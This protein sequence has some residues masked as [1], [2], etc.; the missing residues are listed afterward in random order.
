MFIEVVDIFVFLIKNVK[1]KNQNLKVGCRLYMID[2]QLYN[3]RSLLLNFKFIIFNFRFKNVNYFCDFD[4]LVKFNEHYEKSRDLQAIPILTS[5]RSLLNKY[6]Y[7]S[8]LITFAL[9]KRLRIW[10]IVSS[11][12]ASVSKAN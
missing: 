8:F 5:L 7:S 10:V 2:N 12:S 1:S 3:Y 11:N 6:Y 4:K 9:L